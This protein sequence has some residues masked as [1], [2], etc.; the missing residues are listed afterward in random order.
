M[1]AFSAQDGPGLPIIPTVR[2]P[3]RNLCILEFPRRAKW[4]HRGIPEPSILRN[5]P[6]DMSVSDSVEVGQDLVLWRCPE[7]QP[8]FPVGP[9]VSI[10]E[11]RHVFTARQSC[12]GLQINDRHESRRW[13]ATGP[14][15]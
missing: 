13:H 5:D 4:N 7:D 8:R 3:R 12:F 6:A 10:R 1:L 9:P 15:I 11:S 14:R 2:Q